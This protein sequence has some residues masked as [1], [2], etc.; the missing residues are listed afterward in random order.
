[1]RSIGAGLDAISPKE[2]TGYR[3]A[4]GDQGEVVADSIIQ[5][6]YCGLILER[7][8][9]VRIPVVSYMSCVLGVTSVYAVTR[10]PVAGIHRMVSLS[11]SAFLDAAGSC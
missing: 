10:T 2:K 8:V 5:E 6:R 1:M 7:S 11:E 4:K 3:T 9:M